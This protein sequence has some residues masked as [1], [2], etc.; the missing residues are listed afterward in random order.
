MIYV[1][2]KHHRTDAKV[3]WFKVPKKLQDKV[4]IGADVL[5]LTKRGMVSGEIVSIIEGMSQDTV[6]ELT[7]GY[8][9]SKSIIAVY[10]D[11]PLDELYIPEG[12]LASR[13]SPKK[14]FKRI[15]EFY[16][17]GNFNTSVVV[18]TDGELRDGYTAYLVAKM[19]GA[20]TLRCCYS[21]EENNKNG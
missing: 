7:G 11:V 18:S 3:W 4:Y 21:L 9:P 1:A 12:F 2:I 15:L 16:K 13:P 6:V 17:T 14:I 19:F 10:D 20:E 8:P 5:C